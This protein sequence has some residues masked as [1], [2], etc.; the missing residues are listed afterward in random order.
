MPLRRIKIEELEAPPPLRNRKPLTEEFPELAKMWV[1]ARNNNFRAD[2]FSSGSN[3]EAWFKCPE[4]KDHVFQ[5]SIYSM[6]VA[7]R[8]GTRGCPACKG[9]MVTSR[10]CLE[11]RFPDIAREYCLERNQLPL[12]KISYGSSRRVWWH[13]SGC[14]H[15]WQTAVSNRTQLNSG[16]PACRS[17]KLLDLRDYPE[18]MACFSKTK[19]KGLDPRK[20]PPRAKV[21]WVCKRGLD[22]TW[23]GMFKEKSRG[24]CPYCKG[25]KPSTANNLGLL[26]KLAKQLHPTK[27]KG[28]KAKDLPMNCYKM[29]WWKCREG[30]DHEW[31]ARVNERVYFNSGC[32]FCRNHRLSVTNNLATLSPQLA[33]EWHPSKNGR[34]KPADVV[35]YT[36]KPFWFLCQ[37]GHSYQKPLHLR[38][39]Y[40][41]GCPQCRLDDP[42]PR[43]GR[44][45][46]AQTKIKKSR[47]NSAS[48]SA[49]RAVQKKAS[50]KQPKRGSKGR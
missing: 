45:P 32:P 26:P 43:P 3:I 33:K 22:H 11:K 17:G 39:R 49:G 30:P 27:N 34:L 1:R 9:D 10:N 42:S 41:S 35:A 5:K 12:E 21:W 7:K 47:L 37:E 50:A 13:C 24:F 25:N 31:T 4:G 28:V 2:Q 14:G 46:G 40:G 23:Q 29:V 20:L 6:I 36:T 38:L 48:P 16:C 8:T 18:A 15:Y 44:K 19:N